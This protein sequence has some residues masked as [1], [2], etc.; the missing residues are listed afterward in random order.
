MLNIFSS[1]RIKLLVAILLTAFLFSGGF[2]LFLL[3]KTR[4]KLEDQS[5]AYGESL[6]EGIAAS[7]SRLLRDGNIVDLKKGLETLGESYRTVASIE[8]VVSNTRVASFTKEDFEREDIKEYSAPMVIELEKA[9]KQNL[10]IVK[11]RYSMSFYFESLV[12]EIKSICWAGVLFILGAAVLLFIMLNAIIV[13]RLRRLEIGAEVVGS[14]NLAHV[15][16]IRGRD[17]IGLL[18]ASFNKMTA[19]LKTARDEIE[20][21]N[22]TLEAKVKE[23]TKQL[24][25]AHEK[26]QDMQY[27]IIESGKMATIGM[28][29]AGVAHE[30]NNPMTCIMGYSQLMLQKIKKRVIDDKAIEKYEK[31]LSCIERESQRCK[32][33]VDNL[34]DFARRGSD[35]FESVSMKK[36][37]ENTMTVME[38]QARKWNLELSADYENDD[39][40][41]EGDGD[42][43]QQIFI[44]FMSN[45]HVAMPDGGSFKFTL[46]ESEYDGKA[47]VEVSCSDNGCGIPADKLDRLFDAF[48]SSKKTD[49]NL[50][51]G[52]SISNQIVKDH[53]GL[54]KVESEVGV[55]TTFRVYLPKRHSEGLIS[56]E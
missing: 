4:S 31:F 16:D 35:G 49:K 52:L 1:L 30:L 34:L 37:I 3:D 38:Y 53:L 14:G 56:E 28:I 50:G 27:K 33:I 8:V 24:K 45:A 18:A 11:V 6:A 42:R 21:W 22:R 5:A 48:F 41:I 43:L 29:G 47:C 40:T 10:G 55:G 25:E 19:K 44:N 32:K 23:R 20:E 51:L 46:S 15:I 39:V 17:E 7:C 12:S 36:V 9:G 54:I 13:V 26:I 2:G